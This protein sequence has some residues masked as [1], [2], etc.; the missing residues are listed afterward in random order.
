ME[1]CSSKLHLQDQLL[2]CSPDVSSDCCL[3]DPIFLF[4][5]TTPVDPAYLMDRNL[6]LWFFPSSLWTRPQ[7]MA[8]SLPL[9]SHSFLQTFS[10]TLVASS[11]VDLLTVPVMPLR[12]PS[13]KLPGPYT[14]TRHQEPHTVPPL[15]HAGHGTVN[16]WPVPS[17]N[18]LTSNAVSLAVVSTHLYEA[19]HELILFHR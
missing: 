12:T 15:P 16:R 7:M 2:L 3:D 18:S 1:G 13:S 9:F 17:C 6:N 10:K 14:V 4:L 8:T 11:R 19:H 5:L